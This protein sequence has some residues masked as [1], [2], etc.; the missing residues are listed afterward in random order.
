MTYVAATIYVER[1]S[2]KGILIGK[3]G[4]MLKTIGANARREIERELEI[5]IYL[6]LW[7]KVREKWRESDKDV[8]RFLGESA[9]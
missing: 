6:E 7:V 2:Q 4:E 3:N 5:K 1:D 8:E 9:S